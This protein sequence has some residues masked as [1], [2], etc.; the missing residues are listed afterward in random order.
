MDF[1]HWLSSAAARR[2]DRVAVEAPDA[3]LT[4]REL[5]LRAVRG[6][7]ALHRRAAGRGARVALVLE[8]GLPFVEALHA[9]LLLGVPAMPVDPRLGPS[10]RARLVRDAELVLD[11][12]PGGG[13][14]F[15]L[16]DPPDRGDTALVVHTS[17]T[18]GTPVPVELSFGNV[19]ANAHGLRQALGLGDDERWLCPLPLSHVG[20]LM[21]VLRSAIMATTVVLAPPPFDA[22][23]VAAQLRDGGITVAS[24]VPTQLHKLLDAGATPGPALRRILLGGGPMPRPLLERARDAGFPVCASYGLTQACST[25]TV[26]EPGDLDTAGR[27]LPGVG[28]AVGPDGESRVSGPTVN[29]LGG[30]RTGDLGRLEPDGRLVVTGRRGDLIISGGENVAPA[31]VEAVLAAHPAVA[32]A[33]V[34]GRA[35]ALWGEAVTAFVVP[36]PGVRV[37]V[38]QLHRHCT[39]RLAPFKVP[40]AF[41]LVSSLPRTESGKVRRADLR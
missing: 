17:G 30:L 36:R 23:A 10:E 20:G 35:H 9:C 25:V 34:F 28:V 5:L 7:G 8:P 38:Q 40:K 29:A 14:V 22:E 16:P 2:P 24:L 11:R 12:P 13:G 32:E 33:A 1:G 15:A 21:C 26:S 27:A 18:T 31:E 4:Y 41:E 19:A 6:A 39:A 3:S 37:D